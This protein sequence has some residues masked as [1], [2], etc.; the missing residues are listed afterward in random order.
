MDKWTTDSPRYVAVPLRRSQRPLPK[1]TA[2]SQPRHHVNL[3]FQ[4]GNSLIVK[5]PGL[6]SILLDCLLDFF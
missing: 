2:T 4:Y 3:Q 5:T 1:T 6:N